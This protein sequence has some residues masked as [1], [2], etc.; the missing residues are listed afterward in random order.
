M[1]GKIEDKC[2]KTIEFD[3]EDVSKLKY[4]VI[5]SQL[6]FSDGVSIVMGQIDSVMSN[7]LKIPKSNILYLVGK[8][9]V[10]SGRVTEEEVLWDRNKV[11]QI[12]LSHFKKGYGG[13]LSEKIELAIRDAKEIIR[14]WISENKI[15]ILIVHNSSHPVNFIS[16]IALSRFYRDSIKKKKKTPK[17]ILWWHDSHLEREHF[18]NPS[19][20]VERYLL[21]GVPG[22]FIEYVVFI[23][24]LQF[25]D[26]Q[27]YFLK[28]DKRYHGFYKRIASN[29][30][31]AYN[32]TDTFINS[33]KEIEGS[34]N[35]IQLKQFAKDFKIKSLL[36]QQRLKMNN[37]LFCLQHTRVLERKR[38]DFALKYCH[39][40]LLKAKK[41]NF[42]AI[43]FLVS[44]QGN[45]HRLRKKLETL[46]RKLEKQY[47]TKL[48]LI[49]A[50]D[51]YS[52]TKISFAEYPGIFAKLGGI[53]TYFSEVEGFGNNLLEVLASGLIPVVYK[54]RV[55]KRDI[56]EYNFGLLA[57]DKFEIED[58]DL[59][60]ILRIIK[61]KRKR[62]E[63]V[64]QN[65][66]IL[67]KHFSHKVLAIKLMQAITKKR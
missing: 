37:V 14:E 43:Y 27:K 28:I 36:K 22:R 57:L 15:D 60:E 29:Y 16:S 20:D 4:G 56:E 11:N 31:V 62:K 12:M 2:K 59:K 34:K 44:G 64:N 23:N 32:T 58:D 6:G 8:S 39:Q 54:Y 38:I 46:N 41:K 13:R 49:F 3:H 47:D 30:N 63:L 26:A 21:E 67:R 24:R 5:H 9:S 10:K 35:N 51:Y 45:G 1:N 42:K 40:L 50:E 7:D 17:Y 52:K 53:S 55:F 61:S 25:S 66:E 18:H 33:F 19:N 48:F 65:L